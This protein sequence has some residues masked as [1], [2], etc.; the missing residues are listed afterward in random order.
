MGFNEKGAAP[1]VVGRR[2]EEFVMK[3]EIAK[4]SEIASNLNRILKSFRI[5]KKTSEPTAFS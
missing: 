1:I 2:F 5:L 3:R 4:K